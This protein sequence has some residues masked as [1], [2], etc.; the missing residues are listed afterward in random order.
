MLQ[1]VHFTLKRCFDVIITYLL[2][3][4]FAGFNSIR[5]LRSIQNIS[6]MSCFTGKFMISQPIRYI[7]YS[8]TLQNFDIVVNKHSELT[9]VHDFKLLTMNY[10]RLPR[11][12]YPHMVET[13]N[14]LGP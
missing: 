6:N 5:E 3:T 12:V 8:Q 10:P 4:M 14:Q 11:S 13:V 7:W 9:T 1:G 2:R